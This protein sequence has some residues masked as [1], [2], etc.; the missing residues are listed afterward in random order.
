MVCVPQG[1]HKK[2]GCAETDKSESNKTW[3]IES[4]GKL[5]V[6]DFKI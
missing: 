1:E 3:V 2:S 4:P 6:L 5:M